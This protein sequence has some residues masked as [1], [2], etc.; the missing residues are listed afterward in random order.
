MT[1]AHDAYRIKVLSVPRPIEDNPYQKL[2]YGALETAGGE[3]LEPAPLNGAVLRGHGAG[4]RVLHVHWLWLKG[5]ALRRSVRARRLSRLLQLAAAEGWKI[6]WTAHNL[7][8][9]DDSHQDRQLTRTL[10]AAAHGVIAHTHAAERGLREGLGVDCPVR[11]IPHGHYRDVYGP[12]GSRAQA[13]QALGLTDERPVLLAFG[14]LRPYKGFDDL[15]SRFVRRDVEATL[16]IAGEPVD[17]S[18]TRAIADAASRDDRVIFRPRRQNPEDTNWLFSAA[19][20]VVLP[21]RRVTTS[22]TLVL[23][24][25]FGVPCVIPDDPG[26]LEICEPGAVEAYAPGDDMIDAIERAL[27]ADAA[28]AEAA[29]ARSADA[30]DWAPIGAATLAF[31]QELTA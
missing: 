26:L 5:G 23:A 13:R 14:Q 22:G 21:Y 31:F 29:A 30:L 9:H 2:L 1:P 25:G 17:P 12:R 16:L 19:D 11:V 28:E 24:L 20:R 3:V 4:P 15:V 8:P 10:A 18:V 6:V 27:A 7:L